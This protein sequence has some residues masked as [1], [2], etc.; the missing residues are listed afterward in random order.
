MASIP[1]YGEEVPRKKRRCEEEEDNGNISIEVSG[2]FTCYYLNELIDCDLNKM[3]DGK[4]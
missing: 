3:C 1:S 2:F 4:L